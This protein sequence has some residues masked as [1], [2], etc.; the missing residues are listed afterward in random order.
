MATS[1][2]PSP[3]T[4]PRISI[5][6]FWPISA[7]SSHHRSWLNYLARNNIHC[8]FSFVGSNRNWEGVEEQLPV[9]LGN[10]IVFSSHIMA[11]GWLCGSGGIIITTWVNDKLKFKNDESG[12]IFRLCQIHETVFTFTWWLPS[13]QGVNEIIPPQR[14]DSWCQAVYPHKCSLIYHQITYQP[15]HLL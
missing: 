8:K 7:P 11:C 13:S 9:L 12:K 3:S 5:L 6:Q 15:C 4:A 2:F 14:E 10:P 1:Q